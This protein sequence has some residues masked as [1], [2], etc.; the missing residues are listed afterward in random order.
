MSMNQEWEQTFRT[1]DTNEIR[2]SGKIS[3]VLEKA[4]GIIIVKERA[5]EYRYVFKLKTEGLKLRLSEDG[6]RIEL[7]AEEATEDG[8]RKE[9][10]EF[11][12]PSPFMY[13]ASGNRSDDVSYEVENDAD[14]GYVFAVVA[15]KE[16]MNAAGRAF[17]VTIDPQIVDNDTLQV[18]TIVPMYSKA[19]SSGGTNHYTD[20]T[21]ETLKLGI[22]SSD[23]GKDYYVGWTLY[24][25]WIEYLKGQSFTGMYLVLHRRI[26]RRPAKSF[27]TGT[28]S[29]T[30]RR[31]D[32]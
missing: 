4:Q 30:M 1:A 10:V 2:L 15:E 19:N 27:T 13:D 9:K 22:E 24:K 26:L 7:Y 8:E 11:I 17:P 16:W 14:G 28:R 23:D 12:I 32:P 31:T 21:S 5:E 18:L 25:G 29:P 20:S 6:E 3:L